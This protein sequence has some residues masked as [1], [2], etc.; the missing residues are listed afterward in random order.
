MFD[1]SLY[2]FNDKSNMY[3]FVFLFDKIFLNAKV[4][5][6][7]NGLS[8]KL[9]KETASLVLSN[10]LNFAHVISPVHLGRSF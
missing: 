3:E 5:V 2:I 7:K 4:T 6:Q 9:G 1:I 8:Y 10:T